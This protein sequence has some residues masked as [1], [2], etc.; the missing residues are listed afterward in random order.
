MWILLTKREIK[1]MARMTF[2]KEHSDCCVE[3][4]VKKPEVGRSGERSM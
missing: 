3:D 1:R 4:R 2:L